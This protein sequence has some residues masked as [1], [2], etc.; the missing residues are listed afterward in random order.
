M[1]GVLSFCLDFW[2]SWLPFFIMCPSFFSF[3]C[4]ACF[5]MVCKAKMACKAEVVSK[6]EMVSKAEVVSKAEMV[7]K[8]KKQSCIS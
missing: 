1:G 6:A 2:L 8:A 4:Q 7:C 5:I 3:L